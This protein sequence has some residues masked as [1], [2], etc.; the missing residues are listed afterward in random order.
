MKKTLLLLLIVGLLSSGSWVYADLDLSPVGLSEVQI[1][2]YNETVP[3]STPP[4]SPEKP[5]SD[6]V[7]LIPSPPAAPQPD[8]SWEA[9]TLVKL[10]QKGSDAFSH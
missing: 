2:Y 8:L 3:P 6:S 7:S 9:N 5:H 4:P 1:D 10:D